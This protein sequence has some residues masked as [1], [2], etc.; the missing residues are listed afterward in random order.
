[1]G[2]G[3]GEF[4]KTLRPLRKSWDSVGFILLVADGLL[5][6]MSVQVFV[7]KKSDE[8]SLVVLLQIIESF[9]YASTYW[10]VVKSHTFSCVCDLCEMSSKSLRA[11][12]LHI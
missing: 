2:R 8:E 1:M 7:M 3:V 11:G 10:V 6:Y 5:W 4:K 12:S 9:M